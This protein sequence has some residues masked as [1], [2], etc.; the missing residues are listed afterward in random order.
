MIKKLISPVGFTDPI[1]EN[2]D[3]AVLHLARMLR[4]AVIELYLS[5]ELKKRQTFMKKAI[6]SIAE[7]YHPQVKFWILKDKDSNVAEFDSMYNFF[8]KIL[9]TYENDDSQIV[10][11][12][13]SGTPAMK[14]ALMFINKISN[15]NLESYQVLTPNGKS[16]AD[17]KND[18]VTIDQLEKTGASESKIEEEMQRQIDENLDQGK[19]NDFSR[20]K[21]VEGNTIKR[22]ILQR[23]LKEFIEKY[24]Y[25]AA[26]QLI[27]NDQNFRALSKN[28]QLGELKNALNQIDIAIK[29]Q[30]K[31]P[32]IGKIKNAKEKNA[33]NMYLL[34]NLYANQENV[35]ELLIRSKN[36]AEMMAHDYLN[37]KVPGI[38]EESNNYVYLSKKMENSYGTGLHLNYKNR[39][40]LNLQSCIKVCQKIPGMQKFV[41]DLKE[42]DNQRN[43]RN[44]VAHGSKVIEN[45]TGEINKILTTCQRMLEAVYPQAKCY[46]TYLEKLNGELLEMLK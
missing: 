3:G 5:Q 25:Q 26:C 36:F 42:I 9:R 6:N 37:Q 46:V 29:T 1:R 41:G 12:L 13:S 4:P 11:N 33:V 44:L 45:K 18:S 34:I 2:H 16:N 35:S 23:I 19:N 10:L 8:Q 7:N 27:N 31:M 21:K 20:I 14:A 43:S 39:F 24:Q 17:R 15:L 40:E 32:G 38:I 28:N 22:N 30:G